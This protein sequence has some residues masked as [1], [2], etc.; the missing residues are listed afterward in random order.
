MK[1]YAAYIL[2]ITIRLKRQPLQ[3][4]LQQPLLLDLLLHLHQLIHIPVRKDILALQKRRLLARQPH[5][6]VCRKGN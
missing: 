1:L 6:E 3:P 5:T 2:L 4:H